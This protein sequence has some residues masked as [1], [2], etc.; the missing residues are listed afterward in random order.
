MRLAAIVLTLNEERHIERCITRLSQIVHR[1]Y[2]VDAYSKDSTVEIAQKLGAIVMQRKWKN[3]ADQFNWALENIDDDI[4]W[5]IRIDA[6]EYMSERLKWEISVNFPKISKHVVGISVKRKIIFQGQLVRFGG[7]GSVE[8]L[9]ILKIGHGYCENRFMDEH[10]VVHGRVARFS[11]CIYDENLNTLSWWIN[12][13]NT[14]ANR[15]AIEA[16]DIEYNFL[17]RRKDGKH[18]ATSNANIKRILKKNIYYKIPSRI[19]ALTYYLIRNLFFLGFLDLIRGNYFH[20]LQCYWYRLLVDLKI[21]EIKRYKRLNSVNI[22]TA[23]EEITGEKFVTE[24][25]DNNNC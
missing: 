3:H 5:V 10:L 7:V 17:K 14:Y 22:I 13:H 23:I 9:R 25:I 6:D 15:E 8:S 20:Y 1:I 21:S 4:S 24:D 2:I 12:K 16:L 18:Y 19:R 11:G